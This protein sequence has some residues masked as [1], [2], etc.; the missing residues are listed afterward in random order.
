MKKT[1]QQFTGLI[2]GIFLFAGAILPITV[3]AQN[4]EDSP[5]GFHY[6]NKL[7]DYA[8]DLGIKWVRGN[9]VWGMIQS[10]TDISNGN[11][12]W[13]AFE[14]KVGFNSCPENT[15]FLITISHLGT[16]VA[17]S[18]SY[19]PNEGVYT[20]E[21]WIQYVKALV[22]KYKDYVKYWQVENE[23]KPWMEDYA[24][25]QEITYNAIKE[26]CSECQVVMGGVFWGKGSVSEWDMLNQQILIELNGN[27]VDI[28]D[29]HYGGNADEYNPIFLLDHAKQRL[30]EANFIEIPIWITEMSD[31]SGDPKENGGLD[32]PY[33]SEQIQAQSL[34]KRYVSSLSYGV[35]KVF[36]AWGIFEGF[37]YNETYFDFTGLIYDGTYDHDMGYGVIKLSYYTYKLM[38]EKLEDSDWDSIQTIQES[39]NIYVYKFTKQGEP[40]WVA[41]WDY[42]DD[43]GSSKTITLDVDDIS[44]VIITEAVPNAES[45]D[46][47]N[48]ND[49]PDFFTIET[50]AANDNKITIT[51]GENPVFIEEH[52]T[53][54]VNDINFNNDNIKIYP[55]PTNGI[56]TIQ[57]DNIQ[58]IEILNIKGQVVNSSDDFK[59]SDEFQFNLSEQQKG[60]YFVKIKS[61]NFIS[62]KKII[63][64]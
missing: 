45:G 34:L 38:V 63:I 16:P 3:F 53:T 1:K 48:E 35:E 12:D 43:T 50:K 61:D 39:D 37:H 13:D 6:A 54:S 60:I 21:S 5:F 41:W 18:E 28:F 31:Y 8:S 64:Q 33:Q 4:Y 11:Y 7:P 49:Y 2:L 55:N 27:Y 14:N 20:E 46:D 51:L 62:V 25:L 57:G 36:W 10:E 58:S 32:P 44:S 9:A 17:E 22:S 15:N 47:L 40:I 42:F 56:F 29:Q 23:P 26:E 19:I 52:N 59:S 30:A 24:K